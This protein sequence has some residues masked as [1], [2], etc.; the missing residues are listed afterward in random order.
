PSFGSF[1]KKFRKVASPSNIRK[2]EKVAS[3]VIREDEPVLSQR[4]FDSEYL[5]DLAAREPSFG[6]FFKKVKNFFNPHNIDKAASTAKEASKFAGMLKRQDD[7]DLVERTFD[8]FSEQLTAREME[9]ME[10]L[11]ARDPRFGSFFKKI[12]KFVNF[13]NIKKA[14]SVASLVIREDG[15]AFE[16]FE[17]GFSD[18][19]LDQLD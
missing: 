3:L 2:V 18:L 12:K 8:E 13:K 5:E 16:V 11:A 6:S 4:D 19:D 15:D 14:A 10:E 1:F 7:R 9:V 17:R